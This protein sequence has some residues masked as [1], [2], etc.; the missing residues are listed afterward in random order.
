MS[1]AH[2]RT[3]LSLRPKA[4]RIARQR[5]QLQSISLGEAVSQLVEEAERYAP[6]ARV[7]VRKNGLPVI[8]TPPG[9]PP[10]DPATVRRAIE[11]DW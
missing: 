6:Q 9:T 3:T 8:V 10:I 11:E 5:A 7:E 1:S 4:L 2:R